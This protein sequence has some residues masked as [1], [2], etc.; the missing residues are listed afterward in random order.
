MQ[1]LWAV[2]GLGATSTRM[3][4]NGMASSSDI[5]SAFALTCRIDHTP[6]VAQSN[7]CKVI[8]ARH[9]S[10]NPGCKCLDQNDVFDVLLNQK[11]MCYYSGGSM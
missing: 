4:P 11:V 3:L 1:L 5:E 6:C 7:I 8:C 2:Q 10:Q 9:R